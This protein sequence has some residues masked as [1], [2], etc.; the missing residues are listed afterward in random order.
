MANDDGK[1]LETIRAAKAAGAEDQFLVTLLRQNGWPERRIYAAFSA[2]YE[3]KTGT[4]LPVRGSRGESAR[5]AFMYLLQFATLG[6]WSVAL[7]W[8]AYIVIERAFPNPTDFVPGTSLIQD[9]AGQLASII[10][11]FPIFI[12]VSNAI[13]R[14]VRKRPEALDSGVRKWLTYLALVVAAIA[15]VTDAIFFL[16]SFLTGDLTIRFVLQTLVLLVVAGGIFWYYL[17]TVRTTGSTRANDAVFGWLATA[18]TALAII[19][20]FIHIGSPQYEQQ[21]SYDRQRVND[22]SQIADGLK[23]FKD[24]LPKELPT[25]KQ[26]ELKKD[27][28]SNR[29]YEY[30]PL[31]GTL[32]QLCAVFDEPSVDRI[33]KHSAGRTCFTLDA[34]KDT[35][36]PDYPG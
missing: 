35:P 24:S 12:L 27:P 17:G 36:S 21:L 6:I 10:I 25:S 22:L 32:Y 20:G 5:E 31:H 26:F 23:T 2:Y 1:L 19:L 18:A 29:P 34:S 11:A 4:P 14:D 3:E 28:E 30:N 9:L 16:Q 15:M 13:V 8:L 33:W 7:V